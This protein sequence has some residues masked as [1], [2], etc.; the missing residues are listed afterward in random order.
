MTDLLSS[1]QQCPPDRPPRPTRFP[2]CS[3]TL[4]RIL[5]PTAMLPS[6]SD[7]LSLVTEHLFAKV[8]WA[9]RPGLLTG[10]VVVV[11]GANTGLGLETAIQL[12]RLD[13]SLV[14]M[15][16]RNMAKGDKARERVLAETEL[17][18]ARVAVW[19]LNLA[20]FER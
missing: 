14:I 8:E 13:P 9:P 15:A 19:E 2:S 3:C 4:Y 18:E 20:S 17:T 1:P 11:T 10:R 7:V 16:C 12:G 6:I 5:N